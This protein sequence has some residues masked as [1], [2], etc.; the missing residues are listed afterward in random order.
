MKYLGVVVGPGKKSL[1]PVFQQAALDALRL[2]IV[3]EAWPTAPDGL[4]TRAATLRGE[5]VLGANVTIPHK[6]AILPLMDEVDSLAARIGAVNTVVNEG[7][8]L[9]GHNTDV[10][11]FLRALREDSGLDPAGRRVL[12]AGAGG[13]A[14]AVVVALAE[15]RATS[16]AVISRTFSRALRLVEELRPHC[17]DSELSALPDEYASWA[18]SSSGCDL[19]V[20]CTP[21]GSGPVS[22][23]DD[24][25]SAVPLGVLNSGMLV[26]DLVYVPA[27]T[28]LMAAARSCGARVLGGLPMLIYQGA[29]SFRM[30]TGR[31]AP[32]DVM[33][34]AARKALGLTGEA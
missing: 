3:Y 8:R 14:R 4:E 34:A 22:G 21:A 6:E 2:D 11:G 5:A 30:W 17:G 33:F 10:E 15:A 19:L 7:G 24:Q 25:E 1:S 16:V 26:Y 9:S 29:A 18:L 32:V 23:G 31:D 13:A 28:P 12:V 20:N 27:E